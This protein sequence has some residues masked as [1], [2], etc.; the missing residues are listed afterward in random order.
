MLAYFSPKLANLSLQLANL[1][2]KLAH[3]ILQLANM[4]LKLTHLSPKL[5]Y[6]CLSF[7]PQNG[8]FE[9]QVGQHGA[10]LGK[11]RAQMSFSCLI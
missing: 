10:H 1:S 5:A 2:L 8:P 7:G 9:I 3:L 4:S 11:I 6:L